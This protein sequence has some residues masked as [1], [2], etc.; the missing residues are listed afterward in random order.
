MH[1]L[2]FKR[3]IH[4]PLEKLRTGNSPVRPLDDPPEIII[5]LLQHIGAP[6]KPLV[7][8]KDTVK[9]GQRIG[10]AQ[11][12]VSCPVHS[13]VSGKVK[14]VE[15]RP[16]VSGKSVE[17]VVIIP[18]GQNESMGPSFEIKGLEELSP[19]E[20]RARIRDAGLSGMGGAS[21]PTHVKLTPPKDV[22]VDTVILNGAECEPYLTSDHRLMVE[23]SEKILFGLKVF[24]KALN[25][26]KAWIGIE[27][28]KPEAIDRM[29]KA[30]EEDGTGIELKRLVTK[31][32]QGAE[33]MLI[34]A[35]IGRE[36][37][38]GKIPAHVGVLV[39]NIGTAVAAAN[40]IRDGLPLLERVVTVTGS[41]VKGPGNLLVKIGT[42]IGR[43]IEA[44]GGLEANA[45]K[46]IIGG[47]MMGIAVSNLDIPVIKGT[48]GI[49]VLTDEELERMQSCSCIGC[50][51]C[52]SVC[53]VGLLPTR[54]AHFS[55]N[56]LLDKA[57]AF[58]LFDCIE[59][60]CCSYACP[61][62][63]PLVQWIRY[64]KF[65]VLEAKKKSASRV[66][67]K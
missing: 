16:Q 10:D 51:R 40:T 48:S 14:A 3:G 28:T 65:K 9:R 45:R 6:N 34:K 64:G 29:Q 42:P 22:K 50:G 52:V 13:P 26:Q 15:P 8:K 59:C 2:T 1:L 24:K 11:G 54:I 53:P 60:G 58:G 18:D 61:S 20:L 25:A 4:P 31:Y 23:E 21:F 27:D 55:K 30:V 44:C 63:I 46:V 38:S 41:G 5:P 35:I 33:K 39:Q 62:V 32:P 66:S 17:S 43:C 49:V 57:Q 67:P 37:P 7:K 56:M 47:P 12:F 19:E 36:V